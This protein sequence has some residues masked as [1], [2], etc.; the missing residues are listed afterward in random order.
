MYPINVSKVYISSKLFG[1]ILLKVKKFTAASDIVTTK[2]T[3]VE[4]IL[5][6][7]IP[8]PLKKYDFFSWDDENSQYYGKS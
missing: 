1:N 5:V 2:K 4:S 7:G 6:G 8:T 3:T